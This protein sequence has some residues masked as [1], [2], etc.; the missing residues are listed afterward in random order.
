MPGRS[1]GWR[2]ES[3][4]A[5]SRSK[6]WLKLLLVSL[7]KHLNFVKISPNNQGTLRNQVNYF[8]FPALQKP[9][10]L[11]RDFGKGIAAVGSRL[12]P[13]L[14]SRPRWGG[15]CPI[16]AVPAVCLALGTA[17]SRT[18]LERYRTEPKT[19]SGISHFHDASG[20]YLPLSWLVGDILGE[21][22]RGAVLGGR[23]L[24]V[25]DTGK[26]LS[27]R[28]QN[29]ISAFIPHPQTLPGQS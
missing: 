1:L 7:G 29:P 3:P 26:L 23:A 21:L 22:W 25:S 2:R 19:P 12:L 18:W 13:T 24:R 28:R 4:C 11:R 15:R 6:Y 14:V 20:E 5:S 9:T 27:T 17:S 16:P 8:F 10:C